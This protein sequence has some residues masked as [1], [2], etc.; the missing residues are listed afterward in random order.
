MRL[1]TS[2][3]IAVSAIASAVHAVPNLEERGTYET[4]V[5]EGDYSTP[6]GTSMSPASPCQTH[7]VTVGGTA[8]LVYTPEYVNAAVGDVV[9]FT[10]GT[11]N[12]TLT[13]SSFAQPCVKMDGGI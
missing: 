1:I 10:F 11:K 12:H 7:W 8:G 4:T 13:Q 6:T 3:I 5:S 9:I 2:V